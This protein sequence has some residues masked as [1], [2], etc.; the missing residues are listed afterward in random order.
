M[1]FRKAQKDAFSKKNQKLPN[2]LY[3]VVGGLKKFH[4]PYRGT[5]YMDM[6][7]FQNGYCKTLK[8][9][10]EIALKISGKREK[11]RI[12]KYVQ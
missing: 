3:K 7:F 1:K 5:L 8:E 9:A 12:I 4:K 2:K 6:K 11:A 10:K